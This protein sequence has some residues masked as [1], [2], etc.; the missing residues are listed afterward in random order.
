MQSPMSPLSPKL[1]LRRHYASTKQP[2]TVI[3]CRLYTWWEGWK[4]FAIKP[5]A[6]RDVQLTATPSQGA[7]R[8]LSR[9]N[10]QRGVFLPAD[11]GLDPRDVIISFGH[12]HSTQHC[13][14]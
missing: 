11:A 1:P 12:W 4:L 5:Q 13:S 9:L 3:N 6:V 2:H 7:E 10:R 14:V 8:E